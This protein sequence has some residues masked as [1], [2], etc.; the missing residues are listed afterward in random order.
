RNTAAKW[1]NNYL[2]ISRANEVLGRLDNAE[3]D[4][5]SKSN[6]KGQALFLRAFAYF[7]L[8]KNFGGV[9][10]FLQQAESYADTFKERS[11][12]S[13]IYDQIVNDLEEAISL[14]PA[15]AS[16]VGRVT[17]GAA[18]TLLADVYLGLKRW[19]D[20]EQLLLPLTNGHYALL[21]SYRDV[22]DPT[23]KGNREV[24]FDVQYAEGTS[25]ALHN[26]LPYR[27]IPVL[28]D[29]SVITGVSPAS[30]NG[31]GCYN[32]PTPDLLDA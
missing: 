8:V 6:L 3:F 13:Q 26:Y 25:Q 12:G 18:R 27:F 21:P 15:N 2:I 11:D 29:P 23:N 19:G 7:D 28:T 9:A 10:L 24:I 5:S 14:W 1:S 17:S 20:V 30:T 4:G 31:D 16:A 22:F 32:T